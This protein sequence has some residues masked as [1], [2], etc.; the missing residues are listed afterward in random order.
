V[1]ISI[2]FSWFRELIQEFS[3][4]KSDKQLSNFAVEV[5]QI[6]RFKIDLDKEFKKLT[7]PEEW[8]KK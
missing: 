8:G 3:L 5:L 7:L 4:K 6:V 2:Y 1:K